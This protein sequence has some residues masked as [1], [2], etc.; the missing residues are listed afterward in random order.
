MTPL[1]TSIR[2]KSGILS[3]RHII[4]EELNESY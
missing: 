2:K 3:K 4:L 1:D